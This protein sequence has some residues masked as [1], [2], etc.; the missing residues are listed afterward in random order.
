MGVVKRHIGTSITL[1]LL[2]ICLGLSVLYSKKGDTFNQIKI[3]YQDG[4]Q[5]T[6]LQAIE[7]LEKE[8][9]QEFPINYTLWG[10]LQNQNVNYSELYRSTT[11]T[12]MIISGESRLLLKS[13]WNLQEEDKKGCLIDKKTAYKLFGDTNIVGQVIEYNEKEYIIRGIV[14]KLDSIIV[15]QSTS[16][17]KEAMNYV[18]FEISKNQRAGDIVNNFR[19]RHS[20]SGSVMDFNIYNTWAAV[21]INILPLILLISTFI[22]F[23]KIIYNTSKKAPIHAICYSVIAL[24]FFATMF[25]LLKI[26]IQYPQAFI[27]GQWSDFRFWSNLYTEQIDKVLN[28]LKG[29]K[30]LPELNLVIPFLETLKYAVLSYILYFILNQYIKIKKVEELVLYLVSA[31]VGS[32]L[33]IYLSGLSGNLISENKQIWFLIPLYLC[34]KYILV[35]I[36]DYEKGMT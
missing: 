1:I 18:S 28:V 34:G 13:S 6:G 31:F 17:T 5:L 29:K 30:S 7:I 4:K 11:V 21:L 27:P 12:S 3:L 2:T 26:K 25:S 22:L 32:F 33:V 10:E 14:E 35:K 9:E 15:V 16:E 23:V 24:L 20:L 8:N 19:N 36:Y